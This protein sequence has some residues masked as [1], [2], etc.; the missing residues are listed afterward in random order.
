[1]SCNKVL[2]LTGSDVDTLK[3]F[4]LYLER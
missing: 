1:M 2:N 4:V 3:Q